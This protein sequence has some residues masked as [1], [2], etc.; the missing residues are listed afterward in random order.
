MRLTIKSENKGGGRAG[1]RGFMGV[2]ILVWFSA[3]SVN[4]HLRES[5]SAQRRLEENTA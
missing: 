5:N 4:E 2:N 3:G 1:G